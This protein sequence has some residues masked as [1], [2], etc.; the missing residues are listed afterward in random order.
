MMHSKYHYPAAIQSIPH[1]RKDMDRW[2]LESSVP[3]S[4]SRQLRVIVEE[5]FS[6]LISGRN[7]QVP[8]KVS[9]SLQHEDH[10]IRLHLECPGPAFNPLQ[11][12]AEHPFDPLRGDEGGMG[13]ALVQTFADHMQ[14]V[15]R[16]N[17]NSLQI[18]KKIRSHTNTS[19]V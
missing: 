9:L 7:G 3:A 8:E 6:R 19:E 12:R 15:R 2:A 17:L 4:E 5:L 13:L 11:E 10:Q 16:E 1:I 18:V 14:Y